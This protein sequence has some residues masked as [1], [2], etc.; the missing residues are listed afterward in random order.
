MQNL[1]DK[2]IKNGASI[3][4]FADLKDMKSEITGNLKYGIS[5]AVALNPKII[6]NIKNGPTKEYYKENIRVNKLLDKLAKKTCD[7]L[8]SKGY[9]AIYVSPT[10]KIKKL[11]EKLPDTLPHKT[12][13]TKSGLGWIG[14]CDLLITKDYGSAIRFSSVLTNAELPTGRPITK[15]YCGNCRIC[16]EKCPAKAPSGLNWNPELNRSDF[17]DAFA[18]KDK[19][20][21]LSAK[22]NIDGTIC[23]ICIRHCLWT[24]KYL[25]K[26][27]D[28]SI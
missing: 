22:I 8:I 24:V 12:I 27:K 14:K 9:K 23:G 28:I 20:K 25:N 21:E 4:G 13:A 15:S 16:V 26:S 5:I 6:L 17:Y 19:A 10:Q 3:V 7:Y 11:N 1:K 18:C 2:I